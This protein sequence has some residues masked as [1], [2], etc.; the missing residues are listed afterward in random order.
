MIWKIVFLAAFVFFMFKRSLTYIH[1]FQ[2]EEYDNIRFFRWI[3]KHCVVDIIATTLVVIFSCVFYFFGNVTSVSFIAYAAIF[4]GVSLH[5]KDPRVSAKKKLALTDRVKRILLISYIASF[6]IGV[7][8]TFSA[9]SFWTILVL[10]H[11]QPLLLIFGNSVLVPLESR[12]Q[13]KYWSE[14]SLKVREF[15]PYVVGI[16]GSY[17]KTSVKHILGHVLDCFSPT[18]ITPGSVNTVMGISRVI[19]T[20]LERKHKFLIVEMGAYG[21]GSIA[22]ICKLTPPRLAIVTNIGSAH[23]ER[24]KTIETVAKAKYELVEFVLNVGGNVVT[25]E[26]VLNLFPFSSLEHDYN[27]KVIVCGVERGDIQLVDVTQT[28]KGLSV[29]LAHDGKHYSFEVPLFGLHHAMNAAIAF[30]AACSLGFNPV[31]IINALTSV[32]Q[33]AHRLEVKQYKPGVVLIDD[34]YN[35][36]PIGFRSALELLHVLAEG[37]GRRILVTPGLVELG[38]THVEEHARLGALAANFV[39]ILVAVCPR[40]IPSFVE[41]FQGNRSTGQEVVLCNTFKEA[42]VWISRNA[43]LGDAV[44]LENDLPDIYESKFFL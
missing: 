40:R 30:G 13:L 39:D 26:D 23:L 24:F 22:R 41:A 35:S 38:E 15:S 43:K 36:N 31:D 20:K 11:V 16:T 1:I 18:L 27:D 21:I 42:E 3:L 2:Q 25:Q 6:S 12:I 17:G 4:L 32:P 10:I 5:E 34:A 8:V 28:L 37:K 29:K 19:R 14:A 33:I 7:F 44:L 9:F